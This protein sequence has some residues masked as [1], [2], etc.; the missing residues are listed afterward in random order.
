MISTGF[1]SLDAAIGGLTDRK[2]YLAYG[3]VGSG[4]TA[5]ALNFLHAGLAAGEVVA[6]VTRRSPRMVFDHGR[7]FGWDFESF[8]A[9]SRLV[10]LEYT[11]KVLQN[12]TGTGDENHMI[13]EFHR[14][15]SGTDVRRIVFDPF[16][17]MLEGTVSTN[18]AFRCRALLEQISGLGTTNL[19]IMDTPES[20]PHINHCKDQFHGVMRLEWTSLLSHTYRLTVERSTTL[21]TQA[22]Q[23][24]FQLRYNNGMAELSE[25]E[26]ISG[27]SDIR[28][29]ILTIVPPERRLLFRTALRSTYALTEAAGAA[30]GMAKIAAESPDLIIIDKDGHDLD[31]VEVCRQLRANGLNMPIVMI[32]EHLRRSR[33]RIE[34]SAVGVDAC[35]QKPVDGRLLRLEI[36][37]LLHRYDSNQDRM[38][39]RLPDTKLLA[40]LKRNGTTRTMDPEYFFQRL[41]Q[42]MVYSSEN[43]LPFTV[44]MLRPKGNDENE[45]EECARTAES[46]IRQYDLIF[47]ADNWVVIILAEADESGATAFLKG[48]HN[49]YTTDLPRATCRSYEQQPDFF[50]DIKQLLE[51]AT[52]SERTRGLTGRS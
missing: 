3:P 17:P 30:D 6:L 26:F 11:P 42:E 49:I 21:Q 10:L 43:D 29:K 40:D 2:D 35:L 51:N 32:G 41:Q 4:K 13:S 22:I 31:G 36:Q 15:M 16:T 34:V 44:V 33:D 5:F 14:L 23:I 39:G 48:F 12:M 18:V 50:E 24:D 45:V 47:T 19:F 9:D 38:Q 7:T 28:R 1:R 52:A 27:K 8:V 25:A 46:L 37:N 20:D